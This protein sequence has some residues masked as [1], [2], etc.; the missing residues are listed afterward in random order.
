MADARSYLLCNGSLEQLATA[1]GNRTLPEVPQWL[2]VLMV[3]PATIAMPVKCG[4]PNDASAGH[5]KE[6][7]V[8]LI[9]KVVS[10]PLGERNATL[11][12]AA[13]RA[14]ELVRG[15]SIQDEVAVALFTEAGRQAGLPE[16][17]ANLT[18]RSGVR[19]GQ[20]SAL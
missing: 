10:A 11:H 5:I 1:I 13:C 3:K 18:V 9:R 19:I 7:L 12:W 16:R 15:G 2:A 17:E 6:R 20:N 4:R 8:G 14:G